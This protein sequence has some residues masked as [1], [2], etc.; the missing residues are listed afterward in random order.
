MAL[1]RK[2][3]EE[4]TEREQLA[5]TIM[6]EAGNEPFEG[7]LAVGQ[8]IKNRLG[9]GRWGDTYGKVVLAPGQFSAYNGLTGYAGGE[10]ANNAWMA[11]PNKNSYAAADAVLGGNV[12][13]ATGGALHYYNPSIANPSWGRNAPA[14]ART[15][16][17][18][19]D[20]L[21]GVDAGF[22]QPQR[23][24]SLATQAGM[25][26][27]VHDS[28]LNDRAAANQGSGKDEE[29]ARAVA[30]IEANRR[31]RMPQGDMEVSED[32]RIMAQVARNMA[33]MDAERAGRPQAH[34]P[35]VPSLLGGPPSPAGFGAPTAPG[36][37]PI[38]AAAGAGAGGPPGTPGPM[39][40]MAAPGAGAG[41]PPG[42]PSIMTP[43]SEPRTEGRDAVKSLMGGVASPDAT[44]M[45]AGGPAAPATPA[46]GDQN[47]IER[48][49]GFNMGKD[50]WGEL[51]AGIGNAV[52]VGGGAP[53]RLGQIRSHYQ[54]MRTAAAASET[55][56]A[57]QAF[58]DKR[59]D[60]ETAEGLRRFKLERGDAAA[61]LGVT[62]DKYATA[63][64]RTDAAL[65]IELNERERTHAAE[66]AGLGLTAD[67]YET[68]QSQIDAAL[69]EDLRRRKQ[70]RSDAAEQRNYDRAA[71]NDAIALEQFRFENNQMRE[72]EKIA[73][74]KKRDLMGDRKDTMANRLVR[75]NE[76]EAA[77]NQAD[78]DLLRG[79]LKKVPLVNF[80]G[81]KAGFKHIEEEMALESADAR[82][83]R[84]SL[85][86]YDGML[87]L[88]NK[89]KD[90]KTGKFYEMF[91]GE[92]DLLA[93]IGALSSGAT[94]D[95]ETR[96]ALDAM[97]NR[98]I[99]MQRVEGSGSTSDM[100]ME[101]FAS[102]IPNSKDPRSAMLS[103]IR[104][105]K[106]IAERSIARKNFMS[107]AFFKSLK[108]DDPSVYGNAQEE[109]Q[110][111]VD[112][113]HASVKPMA[114]RTGETSLDNL[115]LAIK[116]GLIDENTP[117]YHNGKRLTDKWD[118]EEAYNEMLRS[119]YGD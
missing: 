111:R 82:K 40:M 14:S 69:R 30:Q 17:G 23:D 100:E 53:S 1:T 88:L 95:A 5:R 116:N 83:A 79:T 101:I 11:T 78:A 59:Y 48:M 119:K 28:I 43:M 74:Q 8:V 7:Q 94:M 27:V 71:S 108:D 117:L 106:N 92:I 86:V 2:Q 3:F 24:T 113:G 20:F 112:E 76:L 38:M 118:V 81:A 73:Y 97:S 93:S 49:F 61:A 64:E 75:A 37:A 16:I 6:A 36:Q 51:I 67:K 80:A 15:T 109:W 22:P 56:A 66:A 29:I 9:T 31:S 89:N 114:Y 45:R 41:G 34:R 90:M 98:L 84:T 110:T 96:R 42:T 91:R 10:G 54:D 62:A 13:D 65:E 63:E 19:H 107:K 102:I 33:A 105:N 60:T 72:D 18:G 104:F 57:R 115:G 32:Q 46:A 39:A 70:D 87:D 35:V 25:S 47:M 85:Q 26:P 77:G 68:K 4:L 50:R 12:A 99:A 58:M 55:A 103:M 44:A 21:R 52:S